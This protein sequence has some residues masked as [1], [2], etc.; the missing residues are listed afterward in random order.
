[1]YLGDVSDKLAKME[2]FVLLLDFLMGIT[3]IGCRMEP[4]CHVP[5]ACVTAMR[6][7]RSVPLILVP[8][9]NSRASFHC[10][11]AFTTVSRFQM[12]RSV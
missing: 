1:M 7:I 4:A 3:E 11:A 8:E 12:V 10:K 6:L 9:A 2:P 5:F